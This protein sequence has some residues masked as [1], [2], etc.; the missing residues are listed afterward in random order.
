[1]PMNR[2]ILFLGFAVIATLFGGELFLLSSYWST[3]TNTANSGTIGPLITS[4][5]TP[6]V[7]V[8][9]V[10]F[11]YLL[12]TV[13]F[14][15]NRELE[16]VKQRLGEI[17]KRESDA[18][19]AVWKAIAQAY[20]LLSELERGTFDAGS[21]E[22]IATAFEEAEIYIFIL[23]AEHQ[24]RFYS[25]PPLISIAALTVDSAFLIVESLVRWK[26][27]VLH[28]CA[29]SARRW[30]CS[31]VHRACLYAGSSDDACC[32]SLTCPLQSFLR[33]R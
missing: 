10:L 18:Y 4:I 14:E 24:G 21:P 20:R 28:S 3:I 26:N 29:R 2:F 27:S 9:T 30:F 13:Q 31:C 6:A 5:F 8:V 17:Y 22:N 33:P 32:L 23:S 11:S 16:K 1:M 15:R 25:A 7:A 12:I 19:F